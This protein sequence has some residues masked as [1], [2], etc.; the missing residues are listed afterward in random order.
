ML[1]KRLL[2][3]LFFALAALALLDF[4][5]CSHQGEAATR[6]KPRHRSAWHKR[7]TICY[8]THT[9]THTLAQGQVHVYTFHSLSPFFPLSPPPTCPL[10]HRPRRRRPRSK[11][12]AARW[13]HRSGTT[14]ATPA[15]KST[16]WCPPHHTQTPSSSVVSLTHAHTRSHTPCSSCHKGILHNPLLL[17]V[18]RNRLTCLLAQFSTQPTT[19]HQQTTHSFLLVQA[20]KMCDVYG[21]VV[22]DVHRFSATQQR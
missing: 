20:E 10:T 14:P 16:S 18:G 11:D 8:S 15:Q 22:Q 4:S 5:I 21:I 2:G 12:R 1:K 6:R 9:H 19:H 7:Y 13:W 3:F 17:R